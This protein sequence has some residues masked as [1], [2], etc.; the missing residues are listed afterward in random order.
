MQPCGVGARSP[1]VLVP[2]KYISIHWMDP[3]IWDVGRRKLKW[4]QKIMIKDV[5]YAALQKKLQ[6]HKHDSCKLLTCREPCSAELKSS[7]QHQLDPP[8]R[9]DTITQGCAITERSPRSS[10]ADHRHKIEIL[11]IDRTAVSA[12]IFRLTELVTHRT[13]R[14]L[15]QSAHNLPSPYNYDHHY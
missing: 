3:P 15:H 7:I 9:S 4:D 12:C 1:V 2:K 11:K 10:E 13:L 6:N 14:L 8:Q 5:S